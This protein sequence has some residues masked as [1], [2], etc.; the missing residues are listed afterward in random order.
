M[1]VLLWQEIGAEFQEN[2]REVYPYAADHFDVYVF[3]DD[4]SWQSGKYQL[5]NLASCPH[6]TAWSY[7]QRLEAIEITENLKL[8][9]TQ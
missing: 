1:W 9:L 8:V 3:D 4:E 2:F 7:G 6:T 5:K